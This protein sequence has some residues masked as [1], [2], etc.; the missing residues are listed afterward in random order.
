MSCGIDQIQHQDRAISRLAVQFRE[1]PNLI[2]YI[3]ALLQENEDLEQV[4]QDI[5]CKRSLDTAENAQLDVIGEIIG[6]DR[7]FEETVVNPFFGFEFSIGAGTFGT[8]G[9][10]GTGEVF[11]SIG[12]DEYGTQILDD[13][14]YRILLRAKI[15]K[16]KT[17]CSIEDII[18]I[19]LIGITAD[20]VEVTESDFRFTVTY[21][22]PITDTEKLILTRTDYMAKPIGT[23][24]SFADSN[25]PFA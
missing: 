17:N 4:F 6:R 18:N 13:D 23:S 25:G 8:I 2:G 3:R 10:A 7:T 14:T 1:S 24:V 20:G 11:R 12:D 15:L 21:T 5:L 16:N 19:A 22:S 9:D